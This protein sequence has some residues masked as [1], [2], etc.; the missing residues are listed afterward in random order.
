MLTPQDHTALQKYTPMVKEI[1]DDADQIDLLLPLLG[2]IDGVLL[3]VNDLT[4]KL[5]LVRPVPRNILPLLGIN[6]CFLLME[7][8][9]V[10]TNKIPEPAFLRAVIKRIVNANTPAT[11]DSSQPVAKADLAMGDKP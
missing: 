8:S 3:A 6:I 7:M 5:D 11:S 2:T 1:V 9:R 10:Q 4:E